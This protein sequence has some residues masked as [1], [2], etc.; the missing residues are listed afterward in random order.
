MPIPTKQLLEDWKKKLLDLSKRNSLINYKTTKR[1]SLQIVY[2]SYDKLFAGLMDEKVFSFAKPIDEELFEDYSGPDKAGYGFD[3]KSSKDTLKEEL[4]ALRALRRRA[5]TITEE[6]GINVLHL[7]FGL[8][9]WKE[10]DNTRDV[11]ASPL[12][13][14]PVTLSIESIVSPF[15]LELQDDDIT[16]NPTLRYKLEHDFNIILPE[17]SADEGIEDFLTRCKTLIQDQPEWGLE[18]SVFLSTF[19]YLKINMYN[20]LGN[21]EEEVCENPIVMALSGDLSSLPDT[22]DIISEVENLDFDKDQKP[23]DVFQVLDADHSQQEAIELAK[24]GVSFVLQGPPGTGKSQTITNIIAECLAEGKKVLFVSEKEAALDVVRNRLYRTGIMDFCLAMHSHKANKKEI[25]NELYRTAGLDKKRF[26]EENLVQLEKLYTNRNKLNTLSEEI[27]KKIS[28]LHKSVYDIN[29]ELAL[30]EKVKG[31]VFDIKDMDTVDFP[32]FDKMKE[33]IALLIKSIKNFEGDRFS[34][35]WGDSKL[36]LLSNQNKHDFRAKITKDKIELFS[37]LIMRLKELIGE[38][39]NISWDS[40]TGLEEFLAFC[41][42]GDIIPENWNNDNLSDNRELALKWDSIRRKVSPA[43]DIVTS[44]FSSDVTAFNAKELKTNVEGLL[45]F[46]K[47]STQLSIENPKTDLFRTSYSRFVDSTKEVEDMLTSL[48]EIDDG[49]SAL[50]LDLEKRD[51]NDLKNILSI[52]KT[53]SSLS[54][55][56]ANWFEQNALTSIRQTVSK[57]EETLK[58]IADIESVIDT[59]F[60][61]TIYSV[62]ISSLLPKFRAEYSS[63]FR[64]F[65]SSYKADIQTLK[66]H[67]KSGKLSYKE[68]LDTL[69]RLKRIQDCQ[70]LL[71]DI[72]VDCQKYF[73]LNEIT[74]ATDFEQYRNICNEL[75][76]IQVFYAGSIPGSVQSFIIAR[77]SQLPGYKEHIDGLVKIC[78]NNALLDLASQFVAGDG[79]KTISRIKLNCEAIDEYTG[80]ISVGISELESYS[81][82]YLKN[83]D[84]LDALVEWEAYLSALKYDQTLLQEKFSF[85]YKGEDTNWSGI[86]EKIDWLKDYLPRSW[87]LSIPEAFTSRLKTEQFFAEK[88]K[89]YCEIVSN[90]RRKIDEDIR[91]FSEWFEDPSAILTCSLSYCK[92]TI[93]FYSD[94][95]EDLDEWLTIHRAMRNCE[96]LGL[97]SFID[98]VVKDKEA[99]CDKYL[100]VFCK[101]FYAIWLDTYTPSLPLLSEMSKVELDQLI[102]D[103]KDQDSVQLVYA[104]LRIY[105]LLS[106]QLPSVSITSGAN[107]Q[108]GVLRREY[109]KKRRQLPLRKLFNNIPTLIQ[110]IKPCLMMSPLSVSL[111]LQNKDYHFDVVIFD[112]ASQIKPE[113]AIGSIIRANQL[114]V[115]GDTHQLPPT[116]FFEKSSNEEDLYDSDEEEVSNFAIEESILD[117]SANILPEKY[118]KWHYRSRHEHLIAFSNAKIYDSRLTTFPSAIDKLDDNGVEFV[119]VPGAVYDR[120]GKRNNPIE[121][122]KV[123]NLVFETFKKYPDRSVGVIANS[124]SQARTIEDLIIKMRTERQSFEA[125]F[126]EEKEEPFFVKSLESVQGDERDTI[127]FSIGYGKDANGRMYNSFGPINLDGGERRLNV[128]ITRAK[129]NFKLVS[130]IQPEDIVITESS[131]QGPRLLKSYIDF[132]K[133]GMEA[134]TG[135]IEDGH[136]VIFDSPFEESVYGFLTEKGYQ[137]ETQVGCAGYRIDLGIKDP[138]KPGRYIL[139]VECDGATYHSSK[140]ARERDRLRQSVLENIGWHFYRIWSTEWIRHTAR[141]KSRLLSAIDSALLNQEEPK[142]QDV[143]LSDIDNIDDL[144]ETVVEE[145]SSDLFS[146]GYVYQDYVEVDASVWNY[147]QS[148]DRIDK[149]L[150]TEAPMH[151]EYLNKKMAPHLGRE[152]V[153]SVVREEVDYVLKRVLNEKYEIV[154]DF[155]YLKPRAEEY[156]MRQVAGRDIA[157]ICPEELRDLMLQIEKKTFGITPEDLELNTGHILGYAHCK[158]RI[159]NILRGVFDSLVK[160]GILSVSQSGTVSRKK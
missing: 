80:R 120:S 148:K 16:V 73:G 91:W 96:S 33:S 127:I 71:P 34:P 23:Q 100:D 27:H 76:R 126:N 89:G 95:L 142:Q 65:K 20:D 55:V 110:T 51:L 108:M 159:M 10:V 133:R 42:K 70:N 26:R 52:V 67:E 22:T 154:N 116:T 123:A 146:D 1:G 12:L 38:D 112:E 31:Y 41:G 144:T 45:D 130:S 84:A 30:L 155:I 105:Q 19:S 21:N 156:K 137:V 147:R 39:Y 40:L 5:K 49:L 14:V 69:N 109:N 97:K 152:K 151:V 75:E 87:S 68:A 15:K 94:N 79:E 125:F 44:T 136:G 78:G 135:E 64:I 141:E 13:L 113:N 6:Q 50:K 140:Y 121:A 74:V 93:N 158:E 58:Q 47:S 92:D 157:M 106:E 129:F 82:S 115:A 139:A 29:G 48:D 124:E 150:E 111:F 138:N 160:D 43:H 83:L 54:I 32:K 4:T 25:I 72:E 8:L 128:A 60:D 7:A 28:P 2:P 56:N 102:E 18:E 62:D 66:G 149:I 24:R 61:D 99:D 98:I 90:T 37:S 36:P 132:A 134:I 103:F 46:L 77:N 53:I 88:C 107:D 85:L 101:R 86:V 35:L 3:I 9:K 118:L 114:I 81:K 145:F 119:F 131:K 11:F 153:T 17:F 117:A 59:R 57:A 63:P 122:Q 143:H 104:R